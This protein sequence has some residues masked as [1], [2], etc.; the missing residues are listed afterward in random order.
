ML[1]ITGRELG[2][3]K[4]KY[5]SVAM[6]NVIS[7]ETPAIA[8][9]TIA[10]AHRHSYGK[11]AR[12]ARKLGHVTVVANTDTERDATITELTDLMPAGIWPPAAH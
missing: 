9:E 7:D 10:N 2:S 8:A 6:L 12:P 5:A 11:E 1:A 3:T 4:S